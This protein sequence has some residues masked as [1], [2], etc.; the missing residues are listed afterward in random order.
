MNWNIRPKI[1]FILFILI[2]ISFH[3]C[4]TKNALAIDGFQNEYF[5][6]KG[7]Q[8]TETKNPNAIDSKIGTLECGNISFTYDYGKYSN[9]GPITP[10]EAFRRTF[11]TYHHIK[12]FEYRM[13][14]PKVY[15]IF[16]DSVEVVNVRRKTRSDKGFFEC[17]PCNTTAE[18]TFMGDTYFYPLTL[19]ENHLSMS[20]YTVSFKE[21]AEMIYKIHKKDNSN[22]GVYITPKK[23]RYKNKNTLS[24]MVKETTLPKEDIDQILKSVYLIINPK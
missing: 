6:I 17:E 2:G 7:L 10:K 23:N 8:C 14:D 5:G 15:K 1:T 16:L 3:S 20:G 19:S 21:D 13:I 11:D 12:F 24:L 22:P 9:P 4:K 18:I